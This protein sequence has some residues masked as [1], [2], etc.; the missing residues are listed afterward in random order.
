MFFKRRKRPRFTTLVENAR[1]GQQPPQCRWVSNRFCCRVKIHPTP[2]PRT[3]PCFWTFFFH[4]SNIFR[5]FIIA[6]YFYARITN[7]YPSLL[8]RTIPVVICAVQVFS[9]IVVLPVGGYTILF[10]IFF[11]TFSE[12]DKTNEE[13]CVGL[14]RGK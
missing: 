13:I 11:E 7:T 5:A 4:M 1:V 12:K 2:L 6:S 8:I 9:N 10:G 3:T 14:L